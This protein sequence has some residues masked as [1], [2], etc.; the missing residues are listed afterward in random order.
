VPCGPIYHVDEVF[1]DPQVKHLG[2]AAPVHSAQLG[3][4]EVVNQAIELT[5][6]PS[7]VVQAT[8]ECGEHTD[9]VLREI[10]YDDQA[11]AGLRAR[12]VV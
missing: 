2:M 6:T 1:A 11:I 8:P 10:G 3:D 4:I 9:E 7:H 5:R 12:K